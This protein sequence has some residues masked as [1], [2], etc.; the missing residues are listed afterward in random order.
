MQNKR[1]I[2]HKTHKTEHFL[3]K[4]RCQG[5]H[6]KLLRR[7]CEF[8]SR[9][10]YQKTTDF[11]VVFCIIAR[12]LFFFEFGQHSQ[13]RLPIVFPEGCPRQACILRECDYHAYQFAFVFRLGNCLFIVYFIHTVCSLSLVNKQYRKRQLKSS[14]IGLSKE[15]RPISR[16]F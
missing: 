13:V 6:L 1:K 4:N 3:H 14:I 15:K 2:L 12:Y 8:D 5:G 10:A 7:Y 11:S 9:R 16:P